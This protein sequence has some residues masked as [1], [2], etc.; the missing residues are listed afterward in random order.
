MQKMKIAYWANAGLNTL[1]LS[2][3]PLGSSMLSLGNGTRIGKL[4]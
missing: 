4:G 1:V 3:I 2:I